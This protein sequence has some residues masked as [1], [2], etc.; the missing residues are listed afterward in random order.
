LD[1]AAK[2]PHPWKQ[3]FLKQPVRLL[4]ALAC[5]S[6]FTFS[7]IYGSSLWVTFVSRHILSKS[8]SW[9][10]FAFV[11]NCMS[12]MHLLVVGTGQGLLFLL[13]SIVHPWLSA[14]TLECW[15]FHNFMWMI[16][17]T[18]SMCTSWNHKQQR[19]V[20]DLS[21]LDFHPWCLCIIMW[22]PFTLSNEK[23]GCPE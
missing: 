18:L 20:T 19:L 4:L 9:Q 10:Q 13:H 22:V 3:T 15:Q 2:Q 17:V 5:A 16:P 7:T 6:L 21:K 14:D 11:Q 23:G 12:A 1:F 8:I